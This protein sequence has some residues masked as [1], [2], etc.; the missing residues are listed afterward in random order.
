MQFKIE[1]L[2]LHP[3]NPALAIALL[4]EMG[5]AEWAKDHVV[6]D[7]VVRGVPGTNEADLAFNYESTRGD[8]PLE[9]EVLHYTQG[10]HWMEIFEPS[11]SH[12]GMHC[13]EEELVEWT[14]FFTSRGIPIAQQVNTRSHT[15]PVIAGQRWYT[16]TIFHTRPILGID[17]KFIVRRDSHAG[18]TE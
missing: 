3:R 6:A 11:A 10:A 7:G 18:R 2:A 4:T 13:T 16:Y 8:K 14:K 15:N 17:C 9:L 12:I 5:L 1:Q